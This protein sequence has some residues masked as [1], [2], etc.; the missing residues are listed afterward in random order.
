MIQLS[1]FPVRGFGLL[2]PGD[3]LAHDVLAQ[4]PAVFL[5]KRVA[6]ARARLAGWIG[7]ARV[8]SVE[9]HLDGEKPTFLVKSAG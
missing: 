6:C 2:L 3:V 8:V 7:P 5:S 1:L 9:V 4:A